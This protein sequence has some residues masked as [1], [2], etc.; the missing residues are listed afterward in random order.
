MQL[1]ILQ[2]RYNCNMLEECGNQSPVQNIFR[3]F[4]SH[5]FKKL[6]RNNRHDSGRSGSL[7]EEKFTG[8]SSQGESR[9]EIALQ[10]T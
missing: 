10:G 5:L 6:A 4:V 7:L 3:T 1:K 9:I 2:V 8:L